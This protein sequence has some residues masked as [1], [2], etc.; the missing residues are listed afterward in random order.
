MTRFVEFQAPGPRRLLVDMGSIIGVITSG[1]DAMAVATPSAPV[2]LILRGGETV[3][4]YGVSAK[5]VL[6]ILA[7]GSKDIDAIYME[8]WRG[9]LEDV[10]RGG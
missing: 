4:I 8:G 2:S 7:L 9:W 3:N 10:K 5:E 1:D 6:A